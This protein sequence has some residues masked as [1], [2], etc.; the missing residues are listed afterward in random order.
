MVVVA[1]VVSVVVVT[2]GGR[3]ECVEVVWTSG[4]SPVK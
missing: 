2:I 4:I 1:V 3:D